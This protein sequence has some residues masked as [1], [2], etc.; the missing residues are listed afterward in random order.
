MEH[1]ILQNVV[2]FPRVCQSS[3]LSACTSHYLTHSYLTVPCLFA[4]NIESVFYFELEH[5]HALLQENRHSGIMTG[6]MDTRSEI[7][8]GLPK[9]LVIGGFGVGGQGFWTSRFPYALPIPA[10][11]IVIPAFW[12]FSI[13]NILQCCKIFSL[14]LLLPASPAPFTPGFPPPVPLVPPPPP[15]PPPP[16]T[17]NE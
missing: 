12:A 4:A 1:R 16:P 13:V 5:I 17:V 15:P 11:S 9:V 14:F 10:P 2:P 8:M 7:C 3:L 6:W